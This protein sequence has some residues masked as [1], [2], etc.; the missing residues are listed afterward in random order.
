MSETS[1]TR[2]APKS[3]TSRHFGMKSINPYVNFNGTAEEAMNFYQSVLGGE[4][5][6]LQRFSDMPEGDKIPENERGRV[7]HVSLRLPNGAVLMAS[8]TLPSSGNP[9]ATGNNFYLSISTDSEAEADAFY[10][11]LSAGGTIEMPLGKTFWN[12]YFGMFADKFGIRWIINYDY[13][14]A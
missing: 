4:F 7:M 2:N 5:L 13:P 6:M 9:E 10:N 14:A 1:R 11:G 12:A 8:D 3:E